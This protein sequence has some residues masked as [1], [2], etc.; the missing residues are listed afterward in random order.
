MGQLGK[1]AGPAVMYSEIPLHRTTTYNTS[2]DDLSVAP[3]G[4]SC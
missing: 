1:Q 2:L 4:Q 3:D